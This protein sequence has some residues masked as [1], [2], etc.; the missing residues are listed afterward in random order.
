MVRLLIKT[1]ELKLRSASSESYSQAS[2]ESSPIKQPLTPRERSKMIFKKISQK[3]QTKNKSSGRGGGE[4]EELYQKKKKTTPVVIKQGNEGAT[5]HHHQ[6][7]LSSVRLGPGSGRA[8]RLVLLDLRR[9]VRFLGRV[10]P[11]GV[12]QQ[13]GVT[14]PVGNLCEKLRNSVELFILVVLSSLFFCCNLK[15][16]QW[17]HR[18]EEVFL[19]RF[20]LRFTFG[21]LAFVKVCFLSQGNVLS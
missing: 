16:P 20:F 17:Q 2:S 8:G 11:P 9:R 10:T 4:G 1:L 12:T 5:S 19:F 14:K 7:Q 6:T 18:L 3:P 21:F 13:Q 15:T